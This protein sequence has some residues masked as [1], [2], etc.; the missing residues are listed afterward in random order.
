MKTVF[1]ILTTAA[2]S[3]TVWATG[4]DA[5]AADAEVGSYWFVP[6]LDSYDEVRT[7]DNEIYRGAIT[8][9]R[10]GEY[11]EL[12]TVGGALTV[13][14][15]D[16][17]EIRRGVPV[18][19]DR[20][21]RELARFL[22][23]VPGVGQHYN[24]DHIKG[25]IVEGLCGLSAVM[26][27]AAQDMH[28]QDSERLAWSGIAIGFFVYVWSWFDAS[29]TASKKNKERLTEAYLRA[30]EMRPVEIPDT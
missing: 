30:T 17:A 23:I 26:I 8:E 5:L 14:E 29:M 21:N 7:K 12:L 9:E 18:T 27:L 11:V 24:G 20:K 25:F 15:E 4:P 2:L 1:S 22:A 10:A 16:V 19:Y 28:P 6:T 3:A 13:R